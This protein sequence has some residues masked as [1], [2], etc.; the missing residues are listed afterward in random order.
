MND[1]L[2]IPLSL[3]GL[4]IILPF[5]LSLSF[6]LLVKVAQTKH[7]FPHSILINI[8]VMVSFL[9]AFKLIYP[10]LTFPSKNVLDGVFI[11][12]I[13][14]NMYATLTR[15]H[16]CN[17]KTKV[18]CQFVILTIGGYVLMKP[19]LTQWSVSAGIVHC[20][21]T[22]ILCLIVWNGLEQLSNSNQP[23]LLSTSL[24]T[25]PLGAAP[26]IAIGG[27]LLI[28]QVT[29]ALAASLGAYWLLNLYNPNGQQLKGLIAV[30]IPPFCGLLLMS[31]HYA[32]VSLPA[33]LIIL[34][35]VFIAGLYRLVPKTQANNPLVNLLL[36]TPLV[37]IPIGISMWII[38]PE[39]SLY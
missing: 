28:G 39:S 13:M 11:L 4:S 6:Q 18:L 14:G 8:S 17:L 1:A 25:L 33:L 19:L 9:V 12:A 20:T 26:I 15:L 23:E 7:N 29:T 10:A 34:T 32:E 22:L 36:F 21:I 38:W 37:I 5:T 24:L 16:H 27:T 2:S 30:V 31:Y 3:V 35:S